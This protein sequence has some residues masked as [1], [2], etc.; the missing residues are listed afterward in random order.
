MKPTTVRFEDQSLRPPEEVRLEAPIADLQRHVDLRLRQSSLKTNVQEHPLE[1]TA[2]PPVLGM[3]FIDEQTEPSNA[4]PSPSSTDLV[5]ELLVVDQAHHFG[6]AQRLPQIPRRQQSREVEQGASGSGAGHI[7]KAGPVAGRKPTVPMGNDSLRTPSPPV[8]S[9]DMNSVAIPFPEAPEV[10]RR[11]VRKNGT[12]PT[13]KNRGQE[14][15]LLRDPRVPN[16]ENAIV[17]A[18]EASGL[19]PSRSRPSIHPQVFE[20]SQRY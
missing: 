3:D 6:L 19:H 15:A 11:T 2:T 17:N 7:S 18:V 4:S 14:P 1:L 10:C 13:R 8:W 16:R 20:L 5:S 12:R 9:N